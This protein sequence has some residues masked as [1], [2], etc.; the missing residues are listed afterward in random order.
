MTT[1]TID[2]MLAELP[3]ENGAGLGDYID[4][5][6]GEIAVLKSAAEKWNQHIWHCEC[7]LGDEDM[8]C[9]CGYDDMQKVLRALE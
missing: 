7:H 3:P 6:K 4:R 1:K 5:L 2:Q 9:T 8:P